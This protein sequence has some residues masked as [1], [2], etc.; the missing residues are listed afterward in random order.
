MSKALTL[1]VRLLGAD[2]HVKFAFNAIDLRPE[3]EL[4]AFRAME[5][6]YDLRLLSLGFITD[7]EFSVRR[8]LGTLPAG[9]QPLS[10]T[11]FYD[12][13]A[14]DASKA[15]PNQGAQE[16]ALQPDTPSNSGGKSQ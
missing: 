4:A 16:K 11:Q 14:V 9:F 10:G 2:V 5:L 1:G 12:G 3:S 7:L 15:S 13:K 8:G 6:D